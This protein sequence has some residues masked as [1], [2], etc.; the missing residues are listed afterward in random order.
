MR[1]GEVTPDKEALVKLTVLGPNGQRQE[2]SSI[3]DTGY[4]EYLT[5]PSA[6]ITI[7][8]L[9]Y[10]YSLPMYLAD[11]RSIRVRVF[12]GIVRWKGQ[13]RH[14]PVQETDGDILLGMSLLY[15]SRLVIDALDGG[16]VSAVDIT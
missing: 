13:D 16:S 11:G 7:L 15:G 3:L 10:Q 9:V 12:D 5:L 4:T 1:I 2:V 6:I 14:I 8:G